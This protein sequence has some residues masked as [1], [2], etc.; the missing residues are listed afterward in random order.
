MIMLEPTRNTC[1]N[2]VNRDFT[3]GL[4]VEAVEDKVEN[5]TIGGSFLSLAY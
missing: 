2:H 3:K 4:Y 1:S 5:R